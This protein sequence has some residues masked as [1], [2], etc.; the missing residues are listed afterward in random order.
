MDGRN[1]LPMMVGAGVIGAI[2]GVAGTSCQPTTTPV[3]VA[4]QAVQDVVMARRFS[5]RDDK[6]VERA[7][8]AF[9]DNG[10]PMMSLFDATGKTRVQMADG[11][12]GSQVSLFDSKGKF[13]VWLENANDSMARV[14]FAD[15]KG[16]AR[17]VMGAMDSG[18]PVVSLFDSKGQPRVGL[19]V[20]SDDAPS[21]GL[22]DSQGASE[23]G[24]GCHGQR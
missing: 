10:G 23:S 3:L 19:G 2:L 11:P 24:I 13:R 8:L 9:M 20:K 4:A 16:K 12:K 22:F 1:R 7:A 14:G 18:E 5:L 6:G 15:S 21:V 17:V